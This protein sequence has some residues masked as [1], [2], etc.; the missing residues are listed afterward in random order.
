[1]TKTLNE[2]NIF[3][4]SHRPK[5]LQSHESDGVIFLTLK[6][7]Y[8]S[9]RV[10]EIFDEK[11]FGDDA[12]KGK[13]LTCKPNGFTNLGCV[14]GYYV[15]VV[16]TNY[17]WL[18]PSRTHEVYHAR[19]QFANDDFNNNARNQS[20]CNDDNANLQRRLNFNRATT[21]IIVLLVVVKLLTTTKV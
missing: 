15:R 11:Y 1:M 9:V 12:I 8:Q 7:P 20:Y 17:N 6:Y 3:D 13:S 21:N 16:N 10:I 5:A 18:T 19:R 4:F 2:N 14:S